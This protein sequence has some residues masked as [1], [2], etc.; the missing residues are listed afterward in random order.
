MKV[1]IIMAVKDTATYLPSCLDSIIDQSYQDWELI[2]VNDHSTDDSLRILEE[3]AQK[4]SRI[5]VF[6][7]QRAKL[8]PTLKEGYPHC[9]GPLINRMDS[10]DKMP[11]Y[12]LEEMVGEWIRHGKGHIVAGGTEH[13]VDE[14][15]VGDGFRRYERWL[16]QVAKDNAYYDEIYKEC[17]IP[18]HCWLLHKDDLD[19]V[20][21]FDREVYPEDYDLCF[22]FYRNNMKIIGLPRIFHYWRDRSNRISRTWDE[23]KDNRYFDLKLEYFFPLDRDTSRPL[24]LWGAGRN[25]KDMAK[26]L[27]QREDNFHWVCDNE[28]KIGLDIYGI[29][30]ESFEV[31]PTLSNPQIMIVVS[32]PDGQQEIKKLLADW[33]KLP[34]DDFWFFA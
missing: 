28:R 24:V 6:S 10:D 30:M 12:K 34:R 11:S 32:S 23:Y 22:R 31:V 33:E 25:G 14:G 1:S 3:Y 27:L 5:K 29:I 2:A 18:S 13:F 16:N 4:D 19:L 17:V 26:L 7:S 8:I 15:E 20:G 9:E 21:A